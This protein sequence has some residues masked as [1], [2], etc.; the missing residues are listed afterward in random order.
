M[1]ARY[2]EENCSKEYLDKIET[3]TEKVMKTKDMDYNEARVFVFKTL[4]QYDSS[5]EMSELR[6]RFIK[7][8]KI[9][10]V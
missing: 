10:K 3:L 2:I 5:D 9:Q 7:K 1:T 8:Y 4:I 6:Y